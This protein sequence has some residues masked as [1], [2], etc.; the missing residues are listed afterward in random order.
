MANGKFA[1]GDGTIASPYLIEDVLDLDAIRK[2]LTASYKIIKDIDLNVAPF[3]TGSGWSPIVNFAGRLDGKGQAIKNIFIARLEA[4]Q[5]LFGTTNNAVVKN[6]G[7]EN[8]NISGANSVGCLIGQCDINTTV[9]NCYSTGQVKGSQY[10]IGGL[11][12]R[13]LGKTDM[14]NCYSLCLVSGGSSQNGGLV[15]DANN[16][17]STITKSYFAG[18]RVNNVS[19]G[20]LVGRSVATTTSSFWDVENSGVST[21]AGGVGLTTQ[22]M[23]TAQTFA[24]VGW[25]TELNDDGGT[26]W[27]MKDGE[28]PKLNFKKVSKTLIL[29]EGEYKSY[30]KG[31]ES[32]E[33]NYL[34]NM[35][36]N[37]TPSPYTA[38]ASSAFSSSTTTFHAWRAF[39]GNKDV[40]NSGSSYWVS[41]DNAFPAWIKID[42]GNP[43]SVNYVHVYHI[44]DGSSRITDFVVQG[45]ND[46]INWTNLK[47]FQ[48]VT[49]GQYNQRFYLDQ[50][51][52][53]TKYRLLI[54]SVNSGT[55]VSVAEVV[56]GIEQPKVPGSW[57][58]VSYSL[59]TATQFQNEGIED[60]TLLSRVS[61][62]SPLDIFQNDYELL[63][64]TDEKPA[65][66]KLNLK[67]V[68]SP[69]FISKITPNTL[70]GYLNGLALT[71][72]GIRTGSGVYRFLLS[73]DKTVWKTFNG[74]NFVDV[75]TTDKNL[76]KTQAM[77]YDQI[78]AM[79][80]TQW[81][82]WQGSNMYIGVFI[83]EESTISVNQLNTINIR[84]L[85]P[86]ESTKVSDVKMYIL[87]TRS[88]INVTF[89]GNTLR[90]SLDDEDTGKVQYRVLLNGSPY[91]PNDGS[92]TPLQTAPVDIAVSINNK[93][94]LIDQSN[95][96]RIEFQDYWGSSDFWQ[97]SF[98]GTYNG[99]L[100]ID[101]SGE[102][103]STHI[104]EILKYLDFGRLI[105]GQTSVEQ[106]ITLR[107]TYGYPLENV[108]VEAN[109]TEFPLGMKAE[110]GTSEINFEGLDNLAFSGQL[111]DGEEKVFYI[112]LKT[113]LG[114]TPNANGKFDIQVHA[115]KYEPPTEQEGSG[116]GTVM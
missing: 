6:L 1:G 83:D 105:A 73:N 47:R 45:S 40:N 41:L 70:F 89:A 24:D 34:L 85:A 79:I 62:E 99:L 93:D 76:I 58:T 29:T 112:R 16:A 90:G 32:S 12:G 81:E 77:T 53:Y 116:D 111:L 49:W 42:F 2:N 95:T 33:I 59:P 17:A 88:T 94:L 35:T 50:T 103:Y 82:K 5:G 14:K 27:L 84:D 101:P 9:A 10:Y 69:K 37:T 72:S 102:Y 21:S 26:L 43:K 61:N 46:N 65:V 87:N 100:F 113:K 98:I 3:N 66:K 11:I 109:Q 52:N 20:G 23:K 106:K 92:Y 30:N 57:K 54:N 28:Y 55:R 115:N 8:A 86:L 38:E 80:S 51:Y 13:F 18:K 31:Q 67:G 4:Q 104:G 75:D 60:L 114:V 71:E 64:W 19:F 74:T 25:D 22:Q 108:I 96:I 48:N 7:I 91:Y 107:N 56:Y 68:P 78:A 39:D 110:F 36:S 97:T 63:T 15:G 44:I